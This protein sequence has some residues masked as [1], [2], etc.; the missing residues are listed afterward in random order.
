M[1]LERKKSA[2]R[3][4]QDFPA[5]VQAGIVALGVVETVLLVAAEIDLRRRPA[6]QVRGP[7]VLWRL[8]C[9]VQPVG[10]PAYLLWGRRAA[11]AQ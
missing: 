9:F 7:K 6:S 3:R 10:P 4:F 8:A 11:A 2:K 1:A 5:P